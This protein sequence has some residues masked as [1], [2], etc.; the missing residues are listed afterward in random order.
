MPDAA[1]SSNIA[2]LLERHA[3]R[4][5]QL[6]PPP[7]EG[8]LTRMVVW[9]C[10]SSSLPSTCTRAAF[11]VGAPNAYFG[12][13][14]ASCSAGRSISCTV[15]VPVAGP[16]NRNS[17]SSVASSSVRWL[18]TNAKSSSSHMILRAASSPCTSTI[19]SQ[20]EKPR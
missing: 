8:V 19:F 18:R 4:V 6:P 13:S 11:T 10:T 2:S 7:V 9:S 3:K 17:L 5:E 15:S 14:S 1:R 20:S 16:L 12:E